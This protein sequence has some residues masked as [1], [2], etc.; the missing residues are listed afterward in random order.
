MGRA[1]VAALQPAC[2]DE[3]RVSE[4][5]GTKLPS[6]TAILRSYALTPDAVDVLTDVEGLFS[7][8]QPEA[9]EDLALCRADNEPWLVSIAHERDAYLNLTNDEWDDLRRDHPELAELLSPSTS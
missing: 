1:I 8:V 7:W 3:R 9:L 2:L 6:D 4:W 5:P